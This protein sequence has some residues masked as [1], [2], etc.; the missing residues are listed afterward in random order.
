M[1]QRDLSIQASTSRDEELDA[2]SPPS[3][4][5]DIRHAEF[6]RDHL[7]PIVLALSEIPSFGCH[8]ALVACQRTYPIATM[9]SVLAGASKK[10]VGVFRCPNEAQ[11]WLDSKRTSVEATLSQAA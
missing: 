8:I 7:A 1:G 5:I 9:I 4:T 3:I 6:S 11:N 2:C 10:N